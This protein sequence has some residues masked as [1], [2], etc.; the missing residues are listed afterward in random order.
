MIARTNDAKTM[1]KHFHVIAN[2]NSIVQLAVQI[3]N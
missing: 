1:I 3:K 2:A